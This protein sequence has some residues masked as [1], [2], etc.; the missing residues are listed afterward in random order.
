MESEFSLVSAED[1]NPIDDN[2]ACNLEDINPI[3]DDDDNLPYNTEDINPID[4]DSSAFN[5]ED[6]NP[7]VDD[8]AIYNGVNVSDGGDNS[9]TQSF[10]DE[11]LISCHEDQSSTTISADQP[12]RGLIDDEEVNLLSLASAGKHFSTKK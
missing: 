4:D 12:L 8:D 9:M 10:L 6:I 2:A 5:A 1:I 7:I 11:G 3:V